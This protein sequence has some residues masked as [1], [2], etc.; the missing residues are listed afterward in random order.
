MPPQDQNTSTQRRL[1]GSDSAT[2]FREQSGNVSL[3]G[4]GWSGSRHRSFANVSW[5]RVFGLNFLSFARREGIA[6]RLYSRIFCLNAPELGGLP[7]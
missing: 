6:A 1:L 2:R 5:R 7:A 4:R 3:D